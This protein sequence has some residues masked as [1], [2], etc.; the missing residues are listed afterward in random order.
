MHERKLTLSMFFDSDD[1][2]ARFPP[3]KQV[4]M[5][6]IG[7]H[8]HDTSFAAVSKAQ[9]SKQQLHGGSGTGAGKQ[10]HIIFAAIDAAMHNGACLMTEQGGL[11]PRGGGGGVRVA[12]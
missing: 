9:Y 7:S 6:F 3:R 8:E 5:V 12:I 11:Q 2:Q 1:S 4:G 10:H